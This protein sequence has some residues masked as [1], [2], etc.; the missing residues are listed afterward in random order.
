MPGDEVP[1]CSAEYAA[2]VPAVPPVTADPL[3]ST[4][5]LA[6]QSATA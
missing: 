2:H 5:E 1:G 3:P 4:V 6:R